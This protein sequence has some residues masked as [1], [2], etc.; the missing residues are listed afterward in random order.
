M[1]KRECPITRE[2]FAQNAEEIT[3]FQPTEPM[4]PREFAI[5]AG[6]VQDPD[7]N[8]YVVKR[9]R[10]GNETREMHN[11]SMGW[12]GAGKCQIT[13]GTERVWVQYNLVLTVIGSKELPK[14]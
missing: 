12:H 9:D 11:G 2:Y 1:T 4:Q 3:S 13:V 10:K 5:P 14:A 7:G 8:S 6:A